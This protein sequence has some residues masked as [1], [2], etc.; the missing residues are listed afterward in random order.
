[1]RHGEYYTVSQ[2]ESRP[3][4][5]SKLSPEVLEKLNFIRR[6][7]VTVGELEVEIMTVD[8]GA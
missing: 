8:Y 5:L 2:D 3:I 6:K 4:D 1:M 7:S